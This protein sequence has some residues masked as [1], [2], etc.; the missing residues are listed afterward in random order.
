MKYKSDKWYIAGN[1]MTAISVVVFAVTMIMMY[2]GDD[3][4]IIWCFGAMPLLAVG[5]LLS[6]SV[7]RRY[8]EADAVNGDPLPMF[9]RIRYAFHNLV[10]LVRTCDMWRN[11]LTAVTGVFI[12][13]AV[14][15]GGLCAYWGI[16]KSAVKNDPQYQNYSSHYNISYQEWSD[17]RKNGDVA[18]QSKHFAEMQAARDAMYKYDQRIKNY[19]SYISHTWPWITVAGGAALF[20]GVVLYTYVW[21]KKKE[22]KT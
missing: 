12:L 17:A 22:G 11:I 18:A 16:A 3:S 7:K 19:G 6:Q 21:H 4:A 14:V 5:I 2:Y 10:L 20:C 9:W 1:I 15:L 8:E 13:A